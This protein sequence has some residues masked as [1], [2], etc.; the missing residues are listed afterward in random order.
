MSY[1]VQTTLDGLYSRDELHAV[2]VEMAQ[3]GHFPNM[4]NRTQWNP[5]WPKLHTIG[6]A[7]EYIVIAHTDK[8]IAV[9]A[10]KVNDELI[11]MGFAPQKVK[12]TVAAMMAGHPNMFK[13]NRREYPYEGGKSWAMYVFGKEAL[14]EMNARDAVLAKWLNDPANI[15]RVH[16]VLSTTCALGLDRF[17]PKKGWDDDV[18]V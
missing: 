16:D 15:D 3:L 18:S 17:K 8:Q 4:K 10:V 13:I 9:S 14:N 7:V 2:D 5:L 11:A 6:E 12:R 1:G